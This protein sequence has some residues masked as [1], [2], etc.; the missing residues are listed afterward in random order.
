MPDI[1]SELCLMA[2]QVHEIHD[3]CEDEAEAKGR[4]NGLDLQAEKLETAVF[5]T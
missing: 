3:N 4:M 5:T 1:E 2:L